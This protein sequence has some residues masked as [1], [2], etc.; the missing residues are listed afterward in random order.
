[1]G[2]VEISEPNNLVV[3]V[4]VD[5][6]LDTHV[7]VALDQ[8]GRKLDT[9]IV[10]TSGHWTP[11]AA[12]VGAAVCACCAW[13]AARLCRPAPTRNRRISFQDLARFP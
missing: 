12:G 4:G 10:I 9:L 8:F 7:A 3:T 6:H 5:T 2:R 11:T 13:P 1:M